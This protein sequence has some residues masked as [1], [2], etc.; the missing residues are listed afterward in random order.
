MTNTSAPALHPAGTRVRIVSFAPDYNGLTGVVDG[1][2]TGD[3]AD[4]NSVALDKRAT[5]RESSLL[6]RPQFLEVLPEPTVSL[7]KVVRPAAP[8]PRPTRQTARDEIAAVAAE[9]GWTSVIPGRIYGM[10]SALVD[11]YVRGDVEVMV[12]YT[13]S[14]TVKFASRKGGA[15]RPDVTGG[16]GKRETVIEWLTEAGEQAPTTYRCELCGEDVRGQ[17]QPTHMDERHTAPEQDPAGIPTVDEVADAIADGTWAAAPQ[18][19]EVVSVEILE[20]EADAQDAPSLDDAARD[21]ALGSLDRLE[22]ILPPVLEAAGSGYG[23]KALVRD[24]LLIVRGRIAELEA[25]AARMLDT[26]LVAQNGWNTKYSR[27]NLRI[28]ELEALVADQQ[29]ELLYQRKVRDQRGERIAELERRDVAAQEMLSRAVAIERERDDYAAT[30]V[31]VTDRNA[32]LVADLERETERLAGVDMAA[33]EAQKSI[34]ELEAE[35]ERL[36]NGERSLHELRDDE[37]IRGDRLA[38]QLCELRVQLAAA[39]GMN[40]DHSIPTDGQLVRDVADLRADL[41]DYPYD[42]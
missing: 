2:G 17:D 26:A 10:P 24:H 34:A 5:A 14:A 36:R 28:A 39:L 21:Q 16:R 20:A 7:V 30:L 23:F 4:W 8:A 25:Q 42:G 41:N 27:L 32:E 6:F 38:E 37:R 11:L 19:P 12:R 40:V 15:A 22:E 1:D 35:N 13:H 33:A 31:R 18:A 9:H 29:R 3:F